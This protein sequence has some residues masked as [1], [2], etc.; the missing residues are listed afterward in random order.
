VK[1]GHSFQVW[2]SRINR[3]SVD[4]A[5][6]NKDSSIVA[7]IELDDTAHLKEQRAEEEAKKSRALASAGIRILRWQVDSLPDVVAIR[8]AFKNEAEQ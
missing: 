1:S 3:M 4:F 5:V 7:V 6:C 2:N 8:L